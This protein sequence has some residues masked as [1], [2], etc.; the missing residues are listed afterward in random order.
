MS[1]RERV[2]LR[3]QKGAIVPADAF[4]QRLLREKGFRVGDIVAGDLAKPRHGWTWKRAHLFGQLL[5][6]N[7]DDF[8]GRSAHQVLKT[9]QRAARIECDVITF[10]IDGHVV[11]EFQPRSLS[12]ESM[13]E[14]TWTE[15]YR[16]MCQYVIRE[17]WPG[18]TEYQITE[19][20]N[21]M[22]EVA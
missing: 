21:L 20:I 16:S 14:A 3:F 22:P 10:R 5:A 7:I 1:R 6:D 12:Y 8:E 2:M 4:S 18:M 11:E 9:I 19:M 13:D 17:Y 15:V